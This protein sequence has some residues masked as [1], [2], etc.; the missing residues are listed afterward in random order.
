MVTILYINES[1]EEECRLHARK[2][3]APILDKTWNENIDALNQLQSGDLIWLY[4][5]GCLAQFI[6]INDNIITIKNI[7][8]DCEERRYSYCFLRKAYKSEI[9]EMTSIL[10]N[11]IKMFNEKNKM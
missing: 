4:D 10:S 5:S 7:N 2:I 3:G 11:A 6:S 1:L 8:N 9:D